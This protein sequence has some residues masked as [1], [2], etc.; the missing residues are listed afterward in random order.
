MAV[1]PSKFHC[2]GIEINANDIRAAS[3]GF[4]HG[5]VTAAHIGRTV[6]VWDVTIKDDDAQL[7]CT[8]R[9]TLAVLDRPCSY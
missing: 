3:G 7:V 1:D 8:S 4:V 6:H 9:V 5:L 2:V